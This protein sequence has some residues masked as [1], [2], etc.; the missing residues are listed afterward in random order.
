MIR[1]G[2]D[3]ERGRGPCGHRDAETGFSVKYGTQ[4]TYTVLHLIAGMR[5]K[6]A[7]SGK[8]FLWKHPEVRDRE[9]VDEGR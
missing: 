1:T 3:L 4:L 7:I 2:P 6:D 5:L 9:L 8:M